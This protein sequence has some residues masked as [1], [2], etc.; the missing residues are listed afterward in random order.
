MSTDRT[1][2]LCAPNL[3]FE[4]CSYIGTGH[5]GPIRRDWASIF[6]K[7]TDRVGTTT[8]ATTRR[9]PVERVQQFLR[10]GPPA[11]DFSI[12]NL[13]GFV[14]HK[15]GVQRQLRGILVANSPLVDNCHFGVAGDHE[16]KPE[17]VG[18]VFRGLEWI[19]ADEYELGP[20]IGKLLGVT[21]Q[22]TEL[23]IAGGSPKA[24]VKH[25]DNIAVFSGIC[26]VETASIHQG[27]RKVRCSITDFGGTLSPLVAPVEVGIQGNES[28]FFR[29]GRG[30]CLGGS[31]RRRAFWTGPIWAA[32]SQ[33][34]C[35][36]CG[37]QPRTG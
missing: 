19:D 28:T 29:C 31:G 12:E 14:D 4:A 21:L 36:G 37:E 34:K 22:L 23:R 17:F 7:L 26:E 11:C 10:L 3:P 27:K 20:A 6:A 15:N 9:G 8:R 30:S 13:A 24:T 33:R 2:G 25:N 35:E 5:L 18:K 32:S 1:R 16:G